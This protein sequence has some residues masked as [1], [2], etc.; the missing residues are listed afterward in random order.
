[1]FL[2]FYILQARPPNWSGVTYPLTLP[3]DEPGCISNA[4][5]NAL[6]KL[7]Q[8]VDAFKKIDALTA[9]V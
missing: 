4:L 1:M 3:F 2:T 5:I 7:T 9:L 6:K 8:C